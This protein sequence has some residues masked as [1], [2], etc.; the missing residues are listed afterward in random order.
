MEKEDIIKLHEIMKKLFEKLAATFPEN[1]WDL[2]R[3]NEFDCLPCHK[4]RS[5]NAHKK[6]ILILGQ[7]VALGFS[8]HRQSEFEK[9]AN[10]LKKMEERL[11]TA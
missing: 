8:H 2:S 1:T 11:Y 7:I 9:V 5:Q 10:R 6:A 3:Y 4:N